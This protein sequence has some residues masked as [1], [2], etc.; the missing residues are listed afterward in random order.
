MAQQKENFAHS[1][2]FNVYIPKNSTDIT[3]GDVV[4]MPRRS[5]PKSRAILGA[6]DRISPISTADHAPLVVGVADSDFNTNTVGS[7]LYAAATANQAVGVY[8]TGVFKLAITNTSGNAGD[9]VKYSSGSTGAQLFVIDNSRPGQA[10]GKIEKT[11]TGAT[12]NDV[13]AVRLIPKDESGI[14]LAYWLE[15]RVL[16][17]CRVST[18][19]ANKQSVVNIGVTYTGNRQGNIVLIKGKY[20]RITRDTELATG[21][22]TGGAVSVCKAMMI[23]AR[24]GSFGM[25]TCSGGITLT[26]FT[27]TGFSNAY[28]VPTTQTSGEICIAYVVFASAVTKATADMI[29]NVRGPVMLPAGKCHWAL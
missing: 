6:L 10:I 24:S 22:F 25:R 1:G 16:N 4:V 21:K 19:T 12:A 26:T 20:C 28:F 17:D 15:N 2:N 5:V 18:P 9:L 11:F 8:K 23:V 3:S 13:Q 14:D 7:T 29:H 27:K